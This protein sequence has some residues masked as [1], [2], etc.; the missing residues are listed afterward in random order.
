M[1]LIRTHDDRHLLSVST[2][3]LGKSKFR[4]HTKQKHRIRSAKIERLL[5][6]CRRADADF[7]TKH[8]HF[9]YVFKVERGNLGVLPFWDLS[10]LSP[11][12]IRLPCYSPVVATRLR[13]FIINKA[14]FGPQW[15]TNGRSW[16][17]AFLGALWT[18]Y[19]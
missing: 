11:V 6:G 14:C 12:V 1:K 17:F 19:H 7:A 16:W 13:N 3:C 4:S 18:F 10:D 15:H 8:T 5:I 2:A 9:V